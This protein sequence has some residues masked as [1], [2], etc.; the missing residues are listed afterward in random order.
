MW[1]QVKSGNHEQKS[2][3][4]LHGYNAQSVLHLKNELHTTQKIQ[5]EQK[6]SNLEG[7]CGQTFPSAKLELR[8]IL[9]IV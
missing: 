5:T 2:R 1:A 9:C 6:I 8:R 3:D 4:S 7:V